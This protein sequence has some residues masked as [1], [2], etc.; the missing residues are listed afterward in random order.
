MLPPTSST[1]RP[2]GD[3]RRIDEARAVSRLPP[4]RSGR[5]SP[6]ASPGGCRGCRRWCGCWRRGARSTGGKVTKADTFSWIPSASAFAGV[7]R[8]GLARGEDT[9]T[10]RSPPPA[11]ASSTEAASAPRPPLPEPRQH[12]YGLTSLT[13][14]KDA[15]L[16]ALAAPTSWSSTAAEGPLKKKKKKSAAERAGTPPARRAG[17]A[18]WPRRPRPA[19][20]TSITPLVRV[21]G[22]TASTRG[23][24]G[25]ARGSPRP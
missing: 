2:P 21:I 25:E 22:A 10:V 7:A 12:D 16:G 3:H 4:S 9:S 15:S 11:T 1:N 18:G 17:S 20:P 6:R 8:R 5:T 23:G 19:G 14:S 24:S 13:T